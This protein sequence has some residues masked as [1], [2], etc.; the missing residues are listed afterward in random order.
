MEPG[1]VFE[2]CDKVDKACQFIFA[3]KKQML[4]K[5]L[6]EL[7]KQQTGAPR[8][9][10]GPQTVQIQGPSS[11]ALLQ[12]R[13]SLHAPGTFRKPSALG[14]P[15]SNI[16]YSSGTNPDGNPRVPVMLMVNPASAAKSSMPVPVQLVSNE[17]VKKMAAFNRVGQQ[18]VHVAQ[19]PTNVRDVD[20][21]R[22]RKPEIYLDIAESE[23]ETLQIKKAL[24]VEAADA[25]LM[26]DMK[27]EQV[28]S[29]DQEQEQEKRRKTSVSDLDDLSQYV[30]EVR[31]K[32]D[33]TEDNDSFME[34]LNA[35]SPVLSDVDETDNFVIDDQSDDENEPGEITP[36][37]EPGETTPGTTN[38]KEKITLNSNVNNVSIEINE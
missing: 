26:K 5:R 25:S 29:S 1:K 16:P 36:G 33:N 18:P 23:Q 19:N 27:I 12:Q 28:W 20:P 13:Q 21:Q 11:S 17:Q 22:K 30:D 3:R 24:D 14:A 38:A 8:I 37:N 10:G 2:I 35:Q 7:K 15:V 34:R 31:Y 6:D 32:V 9:S 4:Q